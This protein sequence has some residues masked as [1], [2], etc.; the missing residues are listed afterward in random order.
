MWKGGVREFSEWRGG[1]IKKRWWDFQGGVATYKETMRSIESNRMPIEWLVF[2]CPIHLNSN[3]TQK[4]VKIWLRLIV[5]DC[6]RLSSIMFDCVQLNLNFC[7][8]IFFLILL[9]Y[10]S[11][12]LHNLSL[13]LYES[14]IYYQFK[15]HGNQKQ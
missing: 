14:K 2:N 8:Y 1:L 12:K 6:T 13:V 10:N 7:I 3:Q 4:N 15:L 9:I 11:W 5:Y